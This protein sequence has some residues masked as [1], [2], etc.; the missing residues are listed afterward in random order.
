MVWPAPGLLCGPQTRRKLLRPTSR[1][2]MLYPLPFP[3]SR[4]LCHA[5]CIN[6]QLHHRSA[7][8]N[9]CIA[10]S[11]FVVGMLDP[12]VLCAM[13]TALE[14]LERNEGTVEPQHSG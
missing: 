5:L 8:S 14:Q 2:D 1:F 12:D 6:V 9:P 13:E 10:A 11:V 3:P 7:K 4:R